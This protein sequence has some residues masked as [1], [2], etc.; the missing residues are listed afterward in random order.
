[1]NPGLFLTKKPTILKDRDLAGE[2][3]DVWHAVQAHR[4][5]EKI[6]NQEMNSDV[7]HKIYHIDGPEP[8]SNNTSKDI[9]KQPPVPDNTSK[10]ESQVLSENINNTLISNNARVEQSV[11]KS[12]DLIKT[13]ISEPQPSTA[14]ENNVQKTENVVCATESKENELNKKSEGPIDNTEYLPKY[15]KQKQ[16]NTKQIPARY[17]SKKRVASKQKSQEDNNQM[18]LSN[19]EHNNSNV[20]NKDVNSSDI[21]LNVSDEFKNMF[22]SLSLNDKHPNASTITF[23]NPSPIVVPSDMNIDNRNDIPFVDD[24]HE[25]IC[26]QPICNK[27]EVEMLEKNIINSTKQP[28]KNVKVPISNVNDH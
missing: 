7:T 13:S 26:D 17:N 25:K 10:N 16:V 8:D 5:R 24:Y 27:T 22:K 18:F 4:E 11:I 20:G 28:T 14:S 9:M 2:L 12:G 23:Q 6:K 21:K 3:K 19:N 15:D 1:M